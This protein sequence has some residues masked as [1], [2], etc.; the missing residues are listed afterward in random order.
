MT[1][2]N[3]E[4]YN[5]LADLHENAQCELNFST[6]FELIVAVILSAQCTDKRV[7]M[8]TERLFKI[9]STP[10]AFVAMPIEE[11]EEHIKSCGFYHNKAKALAETVE[12]SVSHKWTCSALQMHNGAIIACDEAACDELTVGAYKYF[13]DIE[14]KERL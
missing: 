14:K 13:L 3:R 12:G 1:K 6:P 11:L 5:I 7:N 8:V 4:I 9:A 10:E 2:N